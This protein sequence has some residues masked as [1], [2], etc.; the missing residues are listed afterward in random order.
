MSFDAVLATVEA[1][2][3]QLVNGQPGPFKAL[4]SRDE[5]VTL[6]GGLGGAIADR[7]AGLPGCAFDSRDARVTGVRATGETPPLAR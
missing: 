6:S 4:W 7:Q 2:Q 5:D 1:A 3:V